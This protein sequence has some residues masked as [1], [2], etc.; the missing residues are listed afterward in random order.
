[1][2]ENTECTVAGGFVLRT[3]DSLTAQDKLRTHKQ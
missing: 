2:P 1:M 3:V